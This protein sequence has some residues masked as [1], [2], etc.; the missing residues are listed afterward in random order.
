MRQAENEMVRLAGSRL[1]SA[2][3]MVPHHGSNSSSTEGFL[4]LV[5]PQI[6]V[7]SA[8]RGN[9]YG[10]PHKAVMK[11]LRAVGCR[12]YRTDRQGAVMMR[13]QGGRL[14][15]EAYLNGSDQ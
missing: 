3:L 9:W 6:A 14:A 11:R 8:G 2:V 13:T 15:V 4:R 10:F 1:N 12:I 5:K 7:I